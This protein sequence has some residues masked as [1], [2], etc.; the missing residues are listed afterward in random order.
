MIIQLVDAKTSRMLLST[1]V[2][3]KANDF[4]LG[5]LLGGFGGGFGGVGGLGTWQKTP[6][7]KAIRIA[8]LE[9]VKELSKK[10]PQTYFRHGEGIAAPAATTL[11][12]A[13]KPKTAAFVPVPAQG[14]NSES[15]A[16]DSQRIRETQAML[17]QIGVDT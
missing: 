7:E 12:A 8:I 2:E 11:P 13:T 3:G 10:T 15:V 6:V 14:S 4:N 1:T 5:G 16:R 17:K 9:A